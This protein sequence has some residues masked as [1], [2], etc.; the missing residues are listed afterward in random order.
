MS[1]QYDAQYDDKK[2]PQTPICF[3]IHRYLNLGYGQCGDPVWVPYPS[4]VNPVHMCNLLPRFLLSERLRDGFAH[5]V[6]NT[7]HDNYEKLWKRV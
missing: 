7:L 5:A 6:V 2:S 3:H 4:P 1:N